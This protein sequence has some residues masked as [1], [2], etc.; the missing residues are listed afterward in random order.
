MSNRPVTGNEVQG[1][2]PRSDT[3]LIDVSRVKC[4]TNS[5]N[6]EIQGNYLFP[7]TFVL[8]IC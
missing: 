1:D 6:R 5:S 7:V 2:L 4:A 8:L 3:Y